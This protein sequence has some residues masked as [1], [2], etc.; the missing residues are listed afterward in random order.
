MPLEFEM[1]DAVGA[2][3]GRIVLLS[4]LLVLLGLTSPTSLETAVVRSSLTLAEGS[5]IS[6]LRYDPV[7]SVRTEYY[8]NQTVNGS[9]VDGV[10][11]ANATQAYYRRINSGASDELQVQRL[12]IREFDVDGENPIDLRIDYDG[13]A[14]TRSGSFGSGTIKSVGVDFFPNYDFIDSS[15]YK[16]CRDGIIRSSGLWPQEPGSVKIA[17][18]AGYTAAELAGS[19]SV[20]DAS[21]IRE[22]VID[23]ATRRVHKAYSRMKKA[24]AGFVG[25]PFSSERLGDYSYSVEANSLEK[26]LS[27]SSNL[28]AETM[29]LLGPFVNWG[30]SLSS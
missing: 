14:G 20:I 10:W 23:E 3:Y 30:V 15:G 26:Y 7:Q 24:S 19:D 4:D 22:A 2:D 28:L 27:S 1:N 17:Y 11:E 29:E 6:H 5:V 13:R 25:G 21:P 16:V 18:L 12:P 8:P 9:L